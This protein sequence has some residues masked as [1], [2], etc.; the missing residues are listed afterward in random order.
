MTSH[1]ESL[2]AYAD[3]P[4]PMPLPL[5]GNLFRFRFDSMHLKLE[6]WA[7]RYGKLYRFSLGPKKLVVLSDAEIIKV[8]HKERPDKY[9]RTRSIERCSREMGIAG[10]FSVEGEDWQRQRK[11][12]TN[13]LNPTHLRA[14]YPR[15]KKTSERL[16]NRWHQ[17]AQDGEEIDLCRELMR[18]TVDVTTQLAFGIDF[19]TIETDGP[20][21]QRHMDKVF[22]MMHQRTN[23]PFPY[24]RYFKL[25]KDRALDR[26]LKGLRDEVETIIKNVRERMKSDRTLYDSPTNFLEAIIAAKEIEGVEFSN[27]DIFANVCTLLLAGEDTTANTIAW[28]ANY[29]MQK[30]EYLGQAR[31]EVD[32]LLGDA[33][34][35]H[36]MEHL[37][38]MPFLEAFYNESMRLKPVAPLGAV[39]PLDDVKLLGFEIPRG[40]VI[41][42]LHRHIACQEQHF[43]EGTEFQPRRWL[44]GTTSPAC[45]HDAT[46]FIPFGT[47]PRFCPGRNLALLQIKQ[48]LSMLIKNFD[49]ELSNKNN[50]VKEK[51]AFAMMP[52]DL[53]VKIKKRS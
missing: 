21:I 36:E 17:C 9:R 33:S 14:F 8:I 7:E 43:K 3:L 23:A 31:S 38:N 28:T 16:L 44:E 10:V 18:L 19:N 34:V 45:P 22:P 6:E 1:R 39:E 13:A 32:Q 48:I 53:V 2:R 15:L 47:G 52:T 24:W 12:V 49:I 41:M 29:F 40:M 30:P 37:S 11:V 51:L 35:A 25:S 4:G 26:A 27:Q 50:A 20:V 5:I 42:T 46:A